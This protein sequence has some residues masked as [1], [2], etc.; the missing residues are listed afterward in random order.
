[1]GA[2][3]TINI[4]FGTNAA[5]VPGTSRVVAQHFQMKRRAICLGAGNAGARKPDQH[6]EGYCIMSVN[7]GDWETRM[8]PEVLI[9][10]A[11][12]RFFASTR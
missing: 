6:G 2:F 1:M 11:V 9:A 3:S 12:V 8:M 7:K 5:P 10:I 4:T